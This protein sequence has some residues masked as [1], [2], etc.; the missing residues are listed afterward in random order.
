MEKKFF[1][2]SFGTD[3]SRREARNS[4]DT[5]SL[6]SEALM[7][8]P[9]D[10]GPRKAYTQSEYLLQKTSKQLMKEVGASLTFLERSDEFT[11]ILSDKAQ[12]KPISEDS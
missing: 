1:Y 5:K 12:P 10:A 6:I 7:Q 4:N 11:R 3:D 2:R 8:N 9:R